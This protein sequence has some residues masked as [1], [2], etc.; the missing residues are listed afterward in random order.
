MSRA[1]RFLP[2]AV[3]TIAV[4]PWLLAGC[5]ALVIDRAKEASAPLPSRPRL[6]GG[7]IA[8]LQ[9]G[10]S[11]PFQVCVGNTCP[12]P[13]RKSLASA[14]PRSDTAAVGMSAVPPTMVAAPSLELPATLIE[15][16]KAPVEPR[17][18]TVMITFASGAA[19][20][21]PA[22]RK[23]LDAALAHARAA[24]MIEIRGRTDELG[25]TQLNDV[26]A[27]NRALA[28]RDYLHQ[29]QLPEQTLIRVSFKGACCYVAGNDTAEGRAANRRVEIEFR[30]RTQLTLGSNRNDRL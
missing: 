30:Q 28:V 25:A 10:H 19:V 13:T 2:L 21:T 6:V 22:A 17:P 7:S 12:K 18:K 14:T 16:N 20:L 24:E 1:D 3:A 23:V 15:G 4:S 26:L 11:A 9:Y 8:Q 29:K 5:A 27:R